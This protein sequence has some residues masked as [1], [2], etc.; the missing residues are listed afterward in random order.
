MAPYY[1][2]H[3][4]PSNLLPTST[5][6]DSS[7][8]REPPAPLSNN[9]D[10]IDAYSVC[11]K[12]EDTLVKKI[13]AS[14]GSQL[15][16]LQKQILHCRIVGFMFHCHLAD[17][18]IALDNMIA[19]IRSCNDDMDKFLAI[20][21][22]YN[23]F[24]IQVF[25][26][27]HGQRS[28]SYSSG[29]YPSESFEDVREG[30]HKRLISVCRAGP[31]LR[32]DT[33]ER[34]ENRCI[35]TRTPDT[36]SAVS[37]QE[38]RETLSQEVA[39]NVNAATRETQCSH[40]VPISLHNFAGKWRKKLQASVTWTLIERLGFED[41]LTELGDGSGVNT[42]WNTLTL[43][44]LVHKQFDSLRVWFASTDVENRYTVKLHPT[45]T[46]QHLGIESDSVTLKSKD[47]VTLPLPSPDL[48]KLHALCGELAMRT[49]MTQAFFST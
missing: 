34:D 38:F 6:S 44:K 16:L 14:K 49:G 1:Y 40:I 21:R 36:S 8:P 37:N 25:Q 24:L 42:L 15:K 7:L 27:R 20:G 35:V 19:D 39:E 43:D 22:V 4:M 18:D 9:Q 17:S 23:E 47:E 33:L 10:A 26:S 31:T 29:H 3:Y 41:L 30:I 13:P 46:F 11:L 5:M 45:V 12:Y 28:P 48:L 2:Y 32:R